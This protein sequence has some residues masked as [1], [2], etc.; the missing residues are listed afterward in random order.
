VTGQI[1]EVT[2]A[3][4]VGLGGAV[5]YVYWANDGY[6]LTVVA[7]A[8]GYYLACGIPANRPMAFEVARN[9]SA[10][11]NGDYEIPYIWYQFG[12]ADLTRDIELKRRQ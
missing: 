2:P 11:Y 5:I 1:Y 7:D 12:G 8:D 6:F 9:L 4:R 10:G 3:G